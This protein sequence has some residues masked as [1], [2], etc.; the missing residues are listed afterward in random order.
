MLRH[1]FAGGQILHPEL[2]A[3]QFNF[4][5]ILKRTNQRV[6]FLS[7]MMKTGAARP[8]SSTEGAHADI[9]QDWIST[10]VKKRITF[11]MFLYLV[12]APSPIQNPTNQA[13]LSSFFLFF[14]SPPAGMKLQLNLGSSST[15]WRIGLSR[16]HPTMNSC[17][18]FSSNCPSRLPSH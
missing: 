14:C 5:W 1:Y 13:L 15:W 4:D 3:A 7:S 16:L 6:F 8:F 12:K 11:E 18:T 9:M 2:S 10:D 17:S